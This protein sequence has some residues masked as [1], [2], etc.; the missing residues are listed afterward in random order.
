MGT[1]ILV[2][3]D[4]AQGTLL[5]FALALAILVLGRN[6]LLALS[7]IAAAYFSESDRA[8][9]W[10]RVRVRLLWLVF[11]TLVLHRAGCVTTAGQLLYH[12]FFSCVSL[13][14]R[15]CALFVP[16]FML[17][18]VHL[19]E[20]AL[21]IA[22]PALPGRLADTLSYVTIGTGFA[23]FLGRIYSP[24]LRKLEPAWAYL[25]P[26][27][28]LVPFVTG[29]LAM[30]PRWC[31]IDYHVMLLAHILSACFVIAIVPF[32][33]LFRLHVHLTTVLP[34]AAWTPAQDAA[35]EAAPRRA[36]R[37]EFTELVR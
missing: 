33:R 37:P 26:L 24:A 6:A 34:E 12:T 32:A 28:I 18:H 36:R 15:F 29:V 23:L 17:A 22:W 25:K 16:I 4:V 2:A 11:P 5:R 19:W 1:S 20:R 27:I 3:L 13:V 21:G 10:A 31:P 30:H 8:R 35:D 14:F 9:F 7:D